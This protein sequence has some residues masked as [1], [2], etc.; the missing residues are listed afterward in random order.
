MSMI[1]V[2]AADIAAGQERMMPSPTSPPPAIDNAIGTRSN[3]RANIA[4]NPRSPSIMGRTRSS[5]LVDPVHCQQE[6]DDARQHQHRGDQVLERT[7]RNTE[8]RGRVAVLESAGGPQV[9]HP[10]SEERRVGIRSR[11]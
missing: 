5:A 10:S 3:I 8:L 7:Q 11:A 6:M 1:S 9:N 4:A 2:P